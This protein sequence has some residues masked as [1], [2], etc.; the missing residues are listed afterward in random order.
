MKDLQLL[1]LTFGSATGLQLTVANFAI[2]DRG[3]TSACAS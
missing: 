2:V 1:K 3:D